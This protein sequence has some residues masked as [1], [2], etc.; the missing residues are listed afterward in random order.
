[1]RIIAADA[2]TDSLY[3]SVIWVICAE[4][5]NTGEKFTFE[6][7]DLNPQA[8]IDFA[9][10]VDKWVFHNGL[11][12]DVPHTN[13]LLGTEVI[14]PSKVVDTLVVSR[15]IDYD[16]PYGHSLRAWGIRLQLHKGDFKDWSCLSPTMIEYCHNDVAVTVKLFR[17]FSSVIYDKAWTKALRCEHDIQWLCY[18]MHLSGFRFDKGQAEVY[19]AEIMEKMAE[20]EA[21]F[22]VCFP[23]QF[24]ELKRLQYRT[25]KATGEPVKVVQQALDAF[26]DSIIIGDELVVST[27]VPFKPSSTPQR[28]ER[29]WEAGWKPIEKT[30]THTELERDMRLA[31]NSQKKKFDW[32]GSA[33]RME[34]FRTYGWKCSEENLNTLPQDAPR[35]AHKLAEWLTLEGRRSSL[36]EWIKQVREDGRIHGSFQH[37]GAW[38]GRLSHSNPNEANIPAMFHGD[39]DTAVKLVKEQYDGALRELWM[40]D[41]GHYLVGTDAEGIQLRLLAHFMESEDYRNAIL[42]GNKKDQ[43]DIHNVNR[44]ALG[45]VQTTRD[46]AKTFIYAFLLGAGNAKVASIL[47][48]SS[49]EATQAVDSFTSSISGLKELKESKVPYYAKRGFFFGLDGRRVKVPNEHKVLAGMLQNGEAVLMKTAALKWTRE[50]DLLGIRYK[51]CTWPHDEWQTEAYT[52]DEAV[53]IGEV[54]CRAIVDAG[55]ELGMFCPMAGESKV[56]KTWKDTH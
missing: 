44:K 42:L 7:P 11:Q 37:I 9:A 46:D 52:Y 32:A 50:L 26:P 36:A 33:I 10:T 21:E 55:T 51:L 5:I 15:M 48:C 14:I 8:F 4:D 6:R 17:R 18:N 28:V 29:L 47:S 23:P 43:T 30:K 13:R 19:L 31:Q 45:L 27:Y 20:L 40:V 41:E 49:S 25:L 54:Q 24:K 35:G 16:I 1:M 2:E 34:K 22:Q 38:T 3:P 53:K 39:A 12:Y 56:G